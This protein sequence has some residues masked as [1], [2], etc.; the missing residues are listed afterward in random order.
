VINIQYC[1]KDL[2][3]TALC[4]DKKNFCCQQVL[5]SQVQVQVQVLI[6]Q[7]RVQVQVPRSCTRVQLEYNYK[8]QVLQALV[9][10]YI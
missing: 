10:C 2:L 6:I 9:V 1:F 4:T 3:F 8:Y 7:V 5:K